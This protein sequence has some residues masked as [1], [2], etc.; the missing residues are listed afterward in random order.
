E[1]AQQKAKKEPP[2]QPRHPASGELR[3]DASASPRPG[4]ALTTAEPGDG[5]PSEGSSSQPPRRAVTDSSPPTLN[6]FDPR[7]IATGAGSSPDASQEEE[8][9]SDRVR[10]RL[11]RW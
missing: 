6:L 1:Q 8:S 11:A 3:R 9:A 5:A 7:A 2:S 4:D 10:R